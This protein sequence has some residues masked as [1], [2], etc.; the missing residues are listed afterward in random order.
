MTAVMIVFGILTLASACGVVCSRQPVHSALSLV[1]TLFL[2][3]VHFALLG[4]HFV[5]A[6]QVL[7]YAGAIMVLVVF[8]IMLLGLDANV[9]EG[10]AGW[11]SSFGALLTGVAAVVFGYV[12]ISGR[13]FFALKEGAEF[14]AVDG[15]TAGIGANLYSNHI[16]AFEVTSLLILAGIVGAVFLGIE[17]K[18]PLKA[19]R[20]LKSMQA[21]QKEEALR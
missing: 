4:A 2:V 14:W 1:A 17:K 19:G 3:A 7:V 12:A 8:V 18:R 15:T 9:P 10:V 6:V 13:S 5:A 16:F 20:G 21:A 11:G